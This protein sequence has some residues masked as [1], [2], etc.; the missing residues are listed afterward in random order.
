[1]RR[2]AVYHLSIVSSRLRTVEIRILISLT[3]DSVTGPRGTT[4]LASLNPDQLPLQ[5]FHAEMAGSAQKLSAR[6]RRGELELGSML[7]LFLSQD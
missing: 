6:A 4:P 2:L 1:M 7:E 5:S 3:S